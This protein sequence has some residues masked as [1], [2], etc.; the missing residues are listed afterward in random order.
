MLPP[1]LLPT[2]SGWAGAGVVGMNH[3]KLTACTK[4]ELL[5]LARKKRIDGRN[6]MRREELIAAL[7]G[8]PAPRRKAPRPQHQRAAARNT[9]SNG[10]ITA[11]EQVER[12]KYDVGIPTKDLSA[13]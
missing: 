2:R 7:S 8:K 4:K 9:S 12:S 10:T 11:E 1:G 3:A 5:D 13:K 6:G